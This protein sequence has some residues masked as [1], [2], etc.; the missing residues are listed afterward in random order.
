M[1]KQRKIIYVEWIDAVAHSDWD[2]PEKLH[3]DKCQAVGFLVAEED[4]FIGI[5]ATVSGDK[6]NAVITIPKAWIRKRKIL[7]L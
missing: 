4:E 3:I 6:C 2:S 7:R 1:E 5:A